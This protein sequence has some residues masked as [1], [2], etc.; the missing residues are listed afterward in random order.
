MNISERTRPVVRAVCSLAWIGLWPF[1]ISAYCPAPNDTSFV[2]VHIPHP[3]DNPGAVALAH[4]AGI[5]WI[6]IGDGWRRLTKGSDYPCSDPTGHGPDPTEWYWGTLENRIAVAYNAGYSILLGFGN[7]PSWANGCQEANVPPYYGAN[8]PPDAAHAGAYAALWYAVLT[9]PVP[10]LNNYPIGAFVAAFEV[11]NEPGMPNFLSVGPTVYQERILGPAIFAIT[12]ARVQQ[13][14]YP[15]FVVAPSTYSNLDR[16]NP[17]DIGRWVDG[18][19]NSIDIISVHTYGSEASQIQEI[20]NAGSWCDT[21]AC[22]Y[23]WVTEGGFETQGCGQ[24]NCSDRIGLSL[25]NTQ[26][27]CRSDNHCGKNFIFSLVDAQGEFDSGL[28]APGDLVR[29]R[30]CYLE[31]HYYPPLAVTPPCPCSPGSPGCD[32][33]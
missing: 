16:G 11:W 22:G 14:F 4:N 18:Y 2:G 8:I 20:A 28:I 17:I 30:L 10:Q 33:S 12:G 13:G 3:E 19:A 25:V 26:N 7:V 31:S 5:K 1:L 24:A 15:A 21:H 27:A 29:G 6:R 23:V 32:G 9:H